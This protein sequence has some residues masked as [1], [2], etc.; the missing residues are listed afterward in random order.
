MGCAK[1]SVDSEH[2]IGLLTAAGHTIVGDAKD[3]RA[4]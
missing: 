3:A 1:N 4:A 2:L